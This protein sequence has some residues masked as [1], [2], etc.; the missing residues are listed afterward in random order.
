MNAFRDHSPPTL[1]A[2]LIGFVLA[3]LL[4]VLAFGLVNSASLSRDLTAA[5]I[6]ALALM[7]IMVHLHYFLH[8]SFD[9]R[10]NPI[11]AA[12]LFALLIIFIMVGGSIWIMHDLDSQMSPDR[13]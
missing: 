7:Q 3:L 4:T 2:Y 11:F 8:L 1:S 13:Y 9:P 10:R 12:L 6:A 5:A